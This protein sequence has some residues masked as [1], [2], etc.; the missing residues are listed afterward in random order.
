MKRNRRS[1]LA[2]SCTL[3]VCLLGTSA[4]VS[5]T[6]DKLKFNLSRQVKISLDKE[7]F[8]AMKQGADVYFYNAFAPVLSKVS[9]EQIEEIEAYAKSLKLESPVDKFIEMKLIRL[10]RGIDS[11]DA[12]MKLK[13]V[14]LVLDGI[15]QRLHR[16]IQAV[17][18]HPF[19][20][21]SAVEIPENWKEARDQFW[22]AHVAKN[23]FLNNS[24]MLVYGAALMQPVKPAI[25]HAKSAKSLNTLE[26]FGKLA[27]S[28]QATF[29]ELEQRVAEARFIRFERSALTLRSE[30][31]FG[32]KFLASMS[33]QLDAESLIWF[34]QNYQ[35]ERARLQRPDFANQVK[36]VLKE[37]MEAE[38][39]IIEKAHLFRTG[40]HWWLRGRYGRGVE[41]GGLLKSQNVFFVERNRR[42]AVRRAKNLNYAA[43][44]ALYMPRERPEPNFELT[45]L[46]PIGAGGNGPS[47]YSRRHYYTW[48]LE[49]RPIVTTV[50][51]KESSANLA[52]RKNEWTT[53]RPFES[54]DFFW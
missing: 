36:D 12:K 38:P 51:T 53:S 50:S 10:D 44:N 47:H 14:V 17:N 52:D 9:Y 34:L 26:E 20:Q 23:E 8:P 3:L 45:T 43:L 21:N 28:F 24:R 40:M 35:P 42:G 46:K 30:K 1:I 4:G 11:V 54:E 49:D 29:G 2:L 6:D 22:D 16:F 32:E 5:Q 7:I 25:K 13:D 48:A 31:S 37:M 15:N 19:M 39:E 33:L 18:Q 41:F 27:E